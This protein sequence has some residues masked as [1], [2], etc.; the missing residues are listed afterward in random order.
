M[1]VAIIPARGGSRRIP[2]K[3]IRPFHGKPIIA[4]SI[5]AAKQSGLFHAVYVST[6]DSGVADVALD[7]GAIVIRRPWKLAKDEVGTQEVMRDV[8]NGMS[9][10]YACCIYATAPLMA[11]EDLRR[12]F[13][14][15]RG[16]EVPPGQEYRW[17]ADY[18]PRGP[19]PLHAISSCYPPLQ[20]AAQFYWSK[21]SA[22]L[23]GVPYFG[24]ETV[25]VPITPERV[26]DINTEE[27]WARA[28]EMYAA[29]RH[30][31]MLNARGAM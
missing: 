16:C 31:E 1:R 30:S 20:D 5:E 4:Y 10:E 17:L 18:T 19:R 8:L 3:N 25:L 29:M 7:Y 27:D 24:T 13:D 23:D 6:E 2:R 9:Y 26:C 14:L 11:V 28:E 12:G 21:A 15:I 22:L